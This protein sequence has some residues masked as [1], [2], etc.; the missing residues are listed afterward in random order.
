MSFRITE[1]FVQ[2]YRDNVIHLSQQK[3]SRLRDTIRSETVT[4]KSYYFERIGPTQ[5]RRRMVRHGTIQIANTPHTRRRVDLFDWEWAD[6]VDDLDKVRLLISPESEYALSGA[7]AMGRTIDQV[8]V[9]AL[10]GPARA[11]TDGEEIIQFPAT[12]IID[13]QG[14]LTVEKL[15]ETKEKLDKAE[16]DPEDQRFFLISSVQLGNLLRSQQITSADYN[17]V[18]A[19]VAGEVDSFMGFKFIRTEILPVSGRGALKKRTCIAYA[20]NG[21]GLAIG[22]DITTKI[23]ERVDLGHATQIYL[24]MAVGATRIEDSRVVAIQCEE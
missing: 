2:Q 13:S 4:G 12:Q 17:T 18:R 5:A 24:S 21:A 1:A 19:L 9:D 3:G 16:V 14:G 20:E 7:Y 8:I 11:G 23:A 15:I 22:R 6:L 10:I